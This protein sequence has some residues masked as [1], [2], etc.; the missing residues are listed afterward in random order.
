L[1]SPVE[2]DRSHAYRLQKPFIKF[3]ILLTARFHAAYALRSPIG[4][5]I[6][7]SRVIADGERLAKT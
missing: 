4:E 6:Q 3:E 1:L 2:G 7:S 5:N